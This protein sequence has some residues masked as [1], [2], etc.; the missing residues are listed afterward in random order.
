MNAIKEELISIVKVHSH[1][2]IMYSLLNA[3]YIHQQVGFEDDERRHEM[4]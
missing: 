3:R 2:A 4:N 1:E